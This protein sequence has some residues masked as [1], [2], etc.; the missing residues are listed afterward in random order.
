M[1]AFTGGR[2]ASGYRR[3]PCSARVFMSIVPT[4]IPAVGRVSMRITLTP[5]G[6]SPFLSQRPEGV[7]TDEA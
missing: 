1:S 2:R 7:A 6:G 5:C 4:I 3:V